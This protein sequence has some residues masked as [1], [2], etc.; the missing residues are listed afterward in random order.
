MRKK[1]QNFSVDLVV[2]DD[3]TQVHIDNKQIGYVAPTDRGYVGYFGK[4]AVINQAKT[5][6]E[7]IEAILASFN[8]YQ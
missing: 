3:Q 4:Q 5:Q 1:N 6:D 8:L 7:A 2:V